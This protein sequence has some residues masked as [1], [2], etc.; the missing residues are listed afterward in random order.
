[1]NVPDPQRWSQ[2]SPLL[3]ELLDLPV[4]ARPARLAELRS[5]DPALADELA[6]LLTGAEST[7]GVRFM[8]DP[9]DAPAPSLA[10]QRLGAYTIE[11][12]LGQGG[13][14]TV[15][16]ARRDDG[17][18]EGAV[19]IK[20]LHLSLL[21]RAG[22]E[23]F[24]REGNILARLT[25][26]N[27]AHLLDAGVT[28]GGQ[29]YLVIELVKGERFDRHCDARQL[30]IEARLDLFDD[31]LAAVAHAHS[32]LVIHRD[33]KPSNI[34]VTPDGVVKLLD[35]GIAK[36][37]EKESAEAKSTDLTREWGRALT[38]EYAAP[39]QLRGEAVTTATD[40]YALGVLLY[41]LLTHQLPYPDR[42]RGQTVATPSATEP[43]RP[44]ATVTDASLRRRLAGDLDTITLRAMKADAAER[45]PTVSAMQDDLARHLSGHP[46]L[47]RADSW[48]YRTRKFVGRH[49][50]GSAIVAGV[51]LALVGGAHA[52]VAVLLAL[53]AGAALAVWQA[54]ESRAQ[55]TAARE[56]Q[57]RAEAVKQFIASIFTEA[58][59]REGA[60]GVVT[61]TDLLASAI[62]RI[63][64]ELD[65]NPGMAGEL[66][67][68]I[69]SSCSKLGDLPLG[70]RALRAAVPQCERAFGADH[71]L[72][73]HGRLLQLEAYNNAGDYGAAEALAGPLVSALRGQLPA[74]AAMLVE[75]L[76]ETSFLMAKRGNEAASFSAL[77]EAI[78]VGEA[79]LGPLDHETLHTRGLL[80]N[81]LNHFSH[82]REA[83]DAAE[84]AVLRTRQALGDARPHTLLTQQERWYAD[85]LLKNGK[86]GTAEPI[87][88]QVVA[89]Q[90]ALD[91]TL[92]PRVVNAMTTHSLALLGMGRV[93]EAV[94]VAR[95]VVT[96]HAQLFAAETVDTAAF[97]YRLAHCLMPT[98]RVDDIDAELQRDE[99]VWQRLGGEASIV[100]LR[101]LRLRAHVCAWRGEW[102]PA[103][104]LLDQADSAE[105]PDHPQERVRR[106]RVCVLMLRLSGQLEHGIAAARQ[107]L[108]Q[109]DVPGL[110]APDRAQL[111]TELGLLL[112]NRGAAN[113]DADAIEQFAQATRAYDLGEVLPASLPRCDAWLGLGRVHLRAGRGA[114][115]R[116]DF[117]VAEQCWAEA[118]AGSV[119][120]A[121]AR[122]WLSQAMGVSPSAADRADAA[123]M[124]LAAHAVLRVS[125]I[126]TLRALAE[127]VAPTN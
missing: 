64:S 63:A 10:G 12:P 17:R 33:I 49:R 13:T 109:C 114:A 116:H 105:P 85:A 94:A 86:P 67:V 121:E 123:A 11:S 37:L 87:A 4:R 55:A 48:A 56:A 3:D 65:A 126:P 24:R 5:H 80:S 21:G 52:Q 117:T 31:V 61:A 97:T 1:M 30:G 19:A 66:G 103:H 107:A 110:L 77:H 106:A 39:E 51:A 88:R 62:G 41:E 69:A 53:A 2:L 81:T 124:A 89:D 32:H 6:A 29:P 60:G 93:S 59:P 99:R 75:A 84:R 27:I 119:W 26:P 20:L 16:R 100:R 45:Y 35:F 125:A 73:L 18:F 34:I 43:P 82:Y 72:T 36:L 95:E 47:A 98:R 8:T 122:H 50:V 118:H 15:W 112:L 91:G 58:T 25:H 120:H 71:P 111:H 22:A 76:R 115:A 57:R 113:D 83:L 7:R 40:V 127:P 101:R 108:D 54:R 38:P 14:G 96:L 23:R 9:P 90:S 78:A 102:L 74:H 104:T 70:A 68:L 44:S 46:V 92:T 28:P 42:R 79:H